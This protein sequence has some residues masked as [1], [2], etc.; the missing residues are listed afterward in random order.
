[1]NFI[2]RTLMLV[3]ICLSCAIAADLNGR[4]VSV[5]DGDTFTLLTS[6]NQQFRIR[7]AEIDAP[8]SGQPYG[9]SS[10]Q[11]LSRLIFGKDVRVV[12]QATDRY[13]RIVG[14]PYLDSVDVSEE[15]VR[16]GAAWVYPDYVIDQAL[17][18][19]ENEARAASRGVWGLHQS[20]RVEPWNWRRGLGSAGH[21]PTG[22]MIKGNINRK[23]DQIY[24]APG[25]R[26]YGATRIDESKGERWFCNKQDAENAG[27][28]AP[29]N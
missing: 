8:E 2:L 19:I 15:M 16:L 11:A 9:K 3:L 21:L 20:Q 14:R 24:H 17:F 4:V 25:T 5:A 28:R 26:S 10:K 18:D 29:R 12:I 7:L 1:M 27:W 6:E 22:C 23:G 13:G